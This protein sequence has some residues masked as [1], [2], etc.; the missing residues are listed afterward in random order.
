MIFR[1]RKWEKNLKTTYSRLTCPH[2]GATEFHLL[3]GDIFLCEYCNEK[4]RF[5]LEEI[6]FDSENEIFIKE[7][8]EQ[9][10]GK[11]ILLHEKIKETR[12]DLTKYSKLA[13]PRKLLPFSIIC[14][15]I[16]VLILLNYPVIGALLGGVSLTLFVFALTNAKTKN[17]KYQPIANYYASKIVEYENEISFY[18]SIISKLTK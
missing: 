2:C 12:I 11:I 9:F 10:Y 1:P 18:E 4:F 8:T 5:D 3:N 6:D 13:N 17:K 7:L 15:I 14:I 16:S